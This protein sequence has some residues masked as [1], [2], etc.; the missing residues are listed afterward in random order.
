MEREE[1]C[2]SGK[3]KKTMYSFVIRLPKKLWQMV[4]FMKV[5]VF[6]LWLEATALSQVTLKGHYKVR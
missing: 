5:K 2:L 6:S 1:T 3:R 4:L